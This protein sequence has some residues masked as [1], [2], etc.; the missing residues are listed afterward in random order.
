[1][2]QNSRDPGSAIR[3][4]TMVSSHHKRETPGC[5]HPGVSFGLPARRPRGD[6]YEARPC[7]PV[8]SLSVARI[9]DVHPALGLLALQGE[10]TVSAMP[11]KVK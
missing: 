6:A 5:G 3:G 7:G 10:A 8:E 1:M 9:A 2:W 4:E 11:R